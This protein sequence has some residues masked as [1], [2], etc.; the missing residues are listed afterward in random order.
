MIEHYCNKKVRGVWEMEGLCDEFP[1]GSTRFA[2]VATNDRITLIGSS[3]GEIIRPL[4]FLFL[5]LRIFYI[6]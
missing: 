3:L 2:S 4:L 1:G 5:T 6:W